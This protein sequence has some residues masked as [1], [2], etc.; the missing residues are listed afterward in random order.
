[1]R[2]SRSETRV[3]FEIT[4]VAAGGDGVGRS[5]DGR[6]VFVPFTAPGDR[7]HVRITNSRPR[8]ARG[9]VEALVE[10][11][12]QRTDPVCPVFGSCG[13]C[14]WQ[15]I[16]Y[17]TQLDAKIAI[18]SAA[19]QRIGRLSLPIPLAI[20]PSESP[21]R[22]R[23][24][25]RV[26]VS[27]GRVGY[28]RRRSHVLCA[29]RRCP[30][31]VEELD[32]SLSE[33]ADHPPSV[34]GEWELA[35]GHGADREP[36]LARRSS[37]PAERGPRLWLPV[38]ED[39]VGFS[40]GV[41]V[42]ANAGLIDVLA[43]AVS[44]AVGEGGLA[45]DLFA[46]AGFLTLG[47]AR[48]F[49]SVLAVESN[50]TAARDLEFNLREAGVGNVRVIAEPVEKVI[51]KG[52]LENQRPDAIVLDPPR[53]GLPDGVAERLA[54][55]APERIAYLSCDPATLARDLS[56]LDHHGYRLSAVEAFDLFPQ[57]PHVELLAVATRDEKE[58]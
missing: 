38:G 51:G 58:R 14:A 20:T 10:P 19:L 44:T 32:A 50:P 33:L 25:S 56:V 23:S 7:V 21:Y 17:R 29:T 49:E 5:P 42:Q 24:R 30:V 57:T 54:V 8:F 31:L 48:R 45:F 27:D 1:V 34:D 47:L 52:E 39:R 12:S 35:L 3:E 53:T 46:G 4:E 6:V 16:G 18:A 15:H 11:S 22:Y 36:P 9:V 28:R 2:G 43:H 41:F 37:L 40:P 13:G 55:L 26:L